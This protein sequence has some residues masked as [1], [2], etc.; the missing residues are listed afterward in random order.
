MPHPSDA[1]KPMVRSQAKPC[2]VVLSRG[3]CMV[4]KLLFKLFW[5]GSVCASLN[6]RKISEISFLLRSDRNKGKGRQ[7]NS[8]AART[9]K[10]ALM[11]DTIVRTILE[12][13]VLAVCTSFQVKVC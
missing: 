1:P 5:G 6:C 8:S 13:V 12:H 3:C 9:R 10:A 11:K 2:V 7:G 4:Q